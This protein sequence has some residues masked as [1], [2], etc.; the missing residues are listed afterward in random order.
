MY[1]YNLHQAQYAVNGRQGY[2]LTEAL[3]LWKAKFETIKHFMRDVI[4][5]PAL[6]ELGDF[7]QEEWETI[8]PVTVS[9]ALQEPNLERRR[10]M[11]DCI[12]VA[13]LFSQL[14][15]LL[16]DKQTIHKVRKRWNERNEPYERQFEDTYELYQLD[17][18]KLF[19]LRDERTQHV[20]DV[21]AVRC[22][23]TTTAREYWIYVPEDIA[24][25]KAWWQ[26]REMEPDAI[27]AIAWTIR[28]DIRHPKRIYRQGDIVIV[29]ESERSKVV[30]PYHLSKEQYLELMYSE[31]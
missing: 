16:L 28:I 20:E 3:Q 1:S 5:H 11:F 4:T 12:G 26:S 10:V 27:R 17:G 2:S 30:A 22:C 14:E 15:P 7:V 19:P 24:I 23:C 13:R 8:Q 18:A 6:A 31:T 25:N 29:E 9:E 21:Y